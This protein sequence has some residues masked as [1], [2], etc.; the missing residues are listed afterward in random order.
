MEKNLAEADDRLATLCADSKGTISSP[1]E[2]TW[3]RGGK[4]AKLDHG[5]SWN[6]HLASPRAMFNDIAHQR[7]DHATLSFSLPA[8][9]FSRKPQP[10]R[11]SRAKMLTD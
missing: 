11:V 3:K 5:I 8:E 2:F 10:A 6:F 7:F 9:E 4:R 1:T